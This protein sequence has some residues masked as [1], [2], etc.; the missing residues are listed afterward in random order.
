MKSK[1]FCLV[2]LTIIIS[3]C[4]KKFAPL[5]EKARRLYAQNQYVDTID[6]LSL[7]LR[8]WRESDGTEMKAQASQILGMAYKQIGKFDKAMNCFS[9]AIELSTNTYDAAYTLGLLY[10]TASQHKDSV[11]AF[12]EALKMRK[13]DPLALVG[14][15][16]AYFALNDYGQARVAFQRVMDTSPGVSNAVESLAII[17][18]R[19][20][21]ARPS[22]RIRRK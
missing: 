9:D 5:L 15:G 6:T 13:D 21:A 20:K 12:K 19:R 16:N 7:A 2:L 11:R 4:A 17:D 1:L 14:L 8:S 22:K 3:G 18:K 10:L